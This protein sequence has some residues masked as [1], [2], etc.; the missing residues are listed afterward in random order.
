MTNDGPLRL[1]SAQGLPNGPHRAALRVHGPCEIHRRSFKLTEK[2]HES[3]GSRSSRREACLALLE[4][5]RDEAHHTQLA[6]K[7]GE[8]DL[9]ARQD[10]TLV[11]IEVRSI[12]KSPSLVARNTRWTRQATATQAPRT[13]VARTV[14][15]ATRGDTIRC[16]SGPKARL[17]LVGHTPLPSRVRRML[18]N[19]ML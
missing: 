15:M 3:G 6:R 13:L 7:A 10:N 16:H 1:R 19:S 2:M 8:L 17:A 9:I 5:A 11:I 14:R 4:E 12:S 18:A